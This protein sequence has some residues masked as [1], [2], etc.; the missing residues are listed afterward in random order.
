LKQIII[1]LFLF[2]F[3]VIS[4]PIT[5]EYIFQDPQIIN[6]R[7]SLK[8]INPLTNK[9]YYYADDDYD[10]RYNMFDYNYLTGENF[11]YS[12]LG[13]TA[14]E[15][16]VMKNGDTN[17]PYWVRFTY[18]KILHTEYSKDIQL[19]QTDEYE[20]SPVVTGNFVIYRRSGNYYLK[21]FGSEI[22]FEKEVRL[23]E[24]ESD[25]VSYQLLSVSQKMKI[26]NLK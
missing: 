9:I 2:P 4:Q 16:V 26:Q 11:K 14:S 7:P 17:S 10:S 3:S 25:T 23:T 19:T 8:Q 5:L 1:I 20:Y 24:D 21:Y 18:R 15:F 22:K 12:D 13:E 6:A